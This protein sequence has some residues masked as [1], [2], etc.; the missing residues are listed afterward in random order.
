MS[1]WQD[2]QKD[3]NDN[4]RKLLLTLKRQKTYCSNSKKINKMLTSSNR[5]QY[6]HNNRLKQVFITF[7][8]RHL[9]AFNGT[10]D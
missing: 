5:M 3:S 9:R 6:E 8:K 10:N 7:M 2:M 1:E 4:S